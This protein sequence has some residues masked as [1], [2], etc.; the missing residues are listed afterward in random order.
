V[1]LPGYSREIVEKVGRI[2][3]VLW[4]LANDPLLSAVL[5]LYGGTALNLLHISPP[6]R[7]S[8]DL[9]F[10]Y[11]HKGAED[12]GD[13]RDEVDAA[14]K[15]ILDDLGYVRDDIRIQPRYNLGRFQVHYRTSEGLKDSFKIEIGYM[16]RL[17]SSR[18]DTRLP[19]EHP[20]DGRKAFV[21][22]PVPEE[23]YANKWCTMVSRSGKL[24]YPRDLYDVASISKKDIDRSLFIDLVMLEA[25]L[26]ELDLEDVSLG[27]LDASMGSRLNAMLDGRQLNTEQVTS[28]A[29]GF[30]V[31]VIDEVSQRGWTGFRKEFIEDGT[32]RLDLLENPGDINPDI[33]DHPLLRWIR[34]KR[35]TGKL[36]RGKQ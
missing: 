14:I 3:D 11:R 28:V 22:T 25:L 31:R 12:W 18:S 10:N 36:R 2:S 9:D 4:E 24:G 6:P 35:D 19:F 32:I 30:T 8:E 33:E 13:V 29:R 15:V 23:L 17:P 1:P 7:L 34:E 5:S 20:I 26:C 27:S 16:R 21:L